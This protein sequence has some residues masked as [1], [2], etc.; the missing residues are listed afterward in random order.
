MITYKCPSCAFSFTEADKAWDKAAVFGVCPNCDKKLND[1]PVLESAAKHLQKN[2]TVSELLNIERVDVQQLPLNFYMLSAYCLFFAI[3][4][5]LIII[6]GDGVSFFRKCP[7]CFIL[8]TIVTLGQI[9]I[10]VSMYKKR[11][12]KNL[13]NAT[14]K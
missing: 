5:L 6:L 7:L 3:G 8:L 4:F 1:F 14:K 12:R 13:T 9:L 11:N 10:L 2:L